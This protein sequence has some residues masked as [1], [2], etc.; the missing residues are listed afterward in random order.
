ME[1]VSFFP[2]GG[3]KQKLAKWQRLVLVLV[4]F[5]EQFEHRELGAFDI[6]L[7]DVDNLVARGRIMNKPN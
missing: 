1:I 2:D 7:Q 3:P 4:G 6:D 5:D